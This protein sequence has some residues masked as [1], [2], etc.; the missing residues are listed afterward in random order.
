MTKRALIV[1]GLL[2]IVVLMTLSG[3]C[4]EHQPGPWEGGG[5]IYPPS[6]I[7]E[8]TGTSNPVDAGGGEDI[9]IPDVKIIETGPDVSTGG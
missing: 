3:A 5:R 8:A 2:L 4:S 7:G 6:T 9:F 1:P